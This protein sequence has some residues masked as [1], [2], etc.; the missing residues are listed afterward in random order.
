MKCLKVNL[1]E[2]INR[3]LAV[4]GYIVLLGILFVPENMVA[5]SDLYTI[6]SGDQSEARIRNL[7][8]IPRGVVKGTFKGRELTFKKFDGIHELLS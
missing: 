3:C 5:Q 7:N 1:N 2:K 6:A 8:A 4:P